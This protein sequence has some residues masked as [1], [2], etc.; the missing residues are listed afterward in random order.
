MGHGAPKQITS[1]PVDA[2]V[3]IIAA[4]A[5]AEEARL[6][7]VSCLEMI[8]DGK[9]TPTVWKNL[10]KSRQLLELRNRILYGAI[11]ALIK[12]QEKS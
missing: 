6:D 11:D 1:V 4:Q 12:S 8:F 5:N 10:Q 9:E 2:M 3:R 7:V